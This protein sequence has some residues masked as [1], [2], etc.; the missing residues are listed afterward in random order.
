MWQQ[1]KSHNLPGCIGNSSFRHKVLTGKLPEV[2]YRWETQTR[3]LGFFAKSN[4]SS[5]TDVNAEAK[6]C[7]SKKQE[8]ARKNIERVFG[9]K[10]C[11]LLL[12]NA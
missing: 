10:C 2:S 1:K 4:R 12:A 5:S 9:G 8:G 6:K 3:T 11:Y 7:W